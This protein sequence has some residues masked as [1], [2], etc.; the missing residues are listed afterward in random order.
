MANEIAGREPQGWI[1]VLGLLSRLGDDERIE[2]KGRDPEGLC[3]LL[4]YVDCRHGAP[5]RE[6]DQWRMAVWHGR[7]RDLAH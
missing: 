1:Q 7:H 4:D 5:E 3:R 2:L 6:G